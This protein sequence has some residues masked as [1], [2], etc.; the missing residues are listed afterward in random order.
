[1]PQAGHIVEAASGVDSPGTDRFGERFDPWLE[2]DA[3]A[4]RHNAR[5]TARLAE[6]RPIVAVVKNNGYGLGSVNVARILDSLP[7]IAALAVVKTDEAFELLDAGVRKP[8]LL[9]ALAPPRE[10]EEL[11]ARHCRLVPLN[12]GAPERFARIAKRLGRTVPVHVELD[13]GMNRTGVAYHRALPWLERLVG[14]GAVDIEGTFTTL[15][16]DEHE[17]EQLR[18]LRSFAEEARTRRLSLGRLHAASSHTLFFRRDALLDAVRVGLTLWGGYPKGAWPA[19][20]AELRPAFRLRARIT[21]VERLRPGDGV[22]YR[23][24]YIA[25]RPVWVATIP[26]GHVD[27]YSRGAVNGCVALVGGRSFPVIGEVSAS[28]VIVELG[29]EASA[30]VGDEATV[31]GPDDPAIH[32][33]EVAARA[34]ISVYDVLMHLSPKLPVLVRNA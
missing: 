28:H 11:A 14:S 4:V 32:P 10:E 20:D 17:P 24:A 26:V 19:R 15:T 29:E 12:D 22:N 2:L 6:S 34:R 8:V 23:R 7:E 9:M 16:A 31:V 30:A 27:G 3:D 5:E 33:N 25:D 13:T 1:M 18:R 21:R